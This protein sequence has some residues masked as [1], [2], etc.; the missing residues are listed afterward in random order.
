MSS[1]TIHPPLSWKP[2]LDLTRAST[3][4]TPSGIVI[5]DADFPFRVLIMLRQENGAIPTIEKLHLTMRPHLELSMRQ[6]KAIISTLPI[7]DM[8]RLASS[9]QFGSEYPNEAFYRKLVTSGNRDEAV[10]RVASW[11]ASID[12]PGGAS[13]A[14]AELWGVSQRTAFRWLA[15]A[16]GRTRGHDEQPLVDQRS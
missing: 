6:Q 11:A 9:M 10:L 4:I 7:A 12:R 5:D 1:M 14:I 3:G 2:Y 13:G 16:R 15:R 8:I